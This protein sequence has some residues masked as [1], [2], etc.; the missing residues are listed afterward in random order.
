MRTPVKRFPRSFGL[1]SQKLCVP[2][3]CL[4]LC[5]IDKKKAFTATKTLAL[6][7]CLD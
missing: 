4:Y 1:D 6:S 2:D 7:P 5:S 3:K